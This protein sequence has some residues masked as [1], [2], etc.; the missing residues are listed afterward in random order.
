MKG[1]GVRYLSKLGA[2][3]PFVLRERCTRHERAYRS[4]SLLTIY[5][6]SGCFELSSKIPDYVERQL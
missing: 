2:M 1:D 3:L 5:R 6:D 4:C